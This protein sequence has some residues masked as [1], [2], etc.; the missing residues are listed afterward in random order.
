[1]STP[2]S[3]KLEDFRI[4]VYNWSFPKTAIV[5]LAATDHWLTSSAGIQDRYPIFGMK[6]QVAGG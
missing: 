3:Q 4:G 5:A 2:I 1:M 6:N